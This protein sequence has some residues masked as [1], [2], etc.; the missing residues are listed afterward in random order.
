M[1]LYPVLLIGGL[2]LSLV[3]ALEPNFGFASGGGGEIAGYNFV[4]LLPQEAPEI[5]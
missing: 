1:K 2:L 4:I 5:A 3:K